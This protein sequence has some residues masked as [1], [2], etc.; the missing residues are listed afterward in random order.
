[1]SYKIKQ[2]TNDDI[3]F[4]NDLLCVLCD[5][6]HSGRSD[7]FKSGG[8]KYT[9]DDIISL[10]ERNDA[11]IDI[12]IDENGNRVGYCI[13][14]LK[15]VNEDNCRFARRVLYI[16]DLCIS[17]NKRSKGAGSALMAAVKQRATEQSC[18]AIELN[19]WE[20]NKNAIEFYEKQGFL[21]QRRFYEMKL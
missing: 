9:T 17:D 1:M 2:C 15:Q 18:D 3:D 5:L 16:D 13:Q 11:F 21:P 6:H 7:V 14:F 10:L 12:C 4:V 20:F 19:V 8:C